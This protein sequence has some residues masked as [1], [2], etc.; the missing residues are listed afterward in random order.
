M[1]LTLHVQYTPQYPAEPPLLSYV[2]LRGGIDAH[3]LKKIEAGVKATI[4]EN[5]GTAMIYMV[6][7]RIQEILRDHND[8][9]MSMHDLMVRRQMKEGGEEEE[10]EDE[11]SDE[12][13]FRSSEFKILLKKCRLSIL[14]VLILD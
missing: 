14:H 8:P 5:E 7:E 1:S 4:S 10:D 12:G 13:R 11:E 2:H 9:E 6:V 3:V